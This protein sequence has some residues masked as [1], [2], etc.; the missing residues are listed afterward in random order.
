MVPSTLPVLA[1]VPRFDT[2]FSAPAR[3]HAEN[4]SK[5]SVVRV[6]SVAIMNVVPYAPTSVPHPH[7][8]HLAKTDN[9]PVLL[10]ISLTVLLFC[11]QH[12]TKASV[13]RVK[14]AA[15]SMGSAVAAVP[16]SVPH[17][18]PLHVTTADNVPVVI[19][20]L[21][22]V[23]GL[24]AQDATRPCVLRVKGAACLIISVVRCV[25]TFVPGHVSFPIIKRSSSPSTSL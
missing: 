9:V 21:K 2:Q 19:V 12:A 20:F 6:R 23:L 11:A 16:T 10:V 7:F 13:V 1:I 8:L 18:H 5:T 25:P 24:S 15:R 22:S 4:A 17:N 14:R 3:L